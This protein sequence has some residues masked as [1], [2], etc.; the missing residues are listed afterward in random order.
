VKKEH[1]RYVFT[2]LPRPTT[3]G[4][5][6]AATALAATALQDL[7]ES[8]RPVLLGFD[9][10]A[11]DL[12]PM[13]TVHDPERWAATYAYAFDRTTKFGFRNALSYQVVVDWMI[14]EHKSQGLLQTMCGKE[15]VEH[16][17][18]DFEST[19]EAQVAARSLFGLLASGSTR[20]EGFR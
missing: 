13:Q 19:P 2:I 12:N 3:H 16:I 14:A 7:P 4:H 20:E 18:I 17:W 11:T 15:P 1:Y 8:S 5:H 6:Q 10:D 9:T